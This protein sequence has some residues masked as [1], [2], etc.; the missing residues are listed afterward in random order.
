MENSKERDFF[1]SDFMTEIVRIMTE[2]K[3]SQKFLGDAK[4][5]ERDLD[6]VPNFAKAIHTLTNMLIDK[7][8]RK[9]NSFHEKVINLRDC[10]D[11][12]M[13]LE[14]AEEKQRLDEEAEQLSYRLDRLRGFMFLVIEEHLE[15]QG[16]EFERLGIRKDFRIVTFSNPPISSM[17]EGLTKMFGMGGISIRVQG[18]AELNKTT[19]KHP[20]CIGCGEYEGSKTK[21]TNKKDDKEYIN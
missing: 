16:V 8:I 20:V 3:Y 2:G 6:E 1:G 13:L 12:G 11:I 7:F 9:D 19:Q 4:P 10:K 21:N 14:L 17:M 15:K 18:P 5:H